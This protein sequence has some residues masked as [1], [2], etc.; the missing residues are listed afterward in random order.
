MASV[1]P[2]ELFLLFAVALLALGPERFPKAASRAGRWIGRARRAAGQLRRQLE[3]EIS[4]AESSRGMPELRDPV[5]TSGRE[6][7]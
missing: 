7:P 4:L 1:G 2:S 5:E 3:R 6:E